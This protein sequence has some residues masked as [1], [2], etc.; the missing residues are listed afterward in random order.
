MGLKIKNYKV[1]RLGCTLNEAYAAISKMSF[2]GSAIDAVMKIQTTRE[3]ALNP[4]LDGYDE[5]PVCCKWDRKQSIAE[6][7]YEA[8]KTQ[9]F[10]DWENDII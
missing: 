9:G 3:N 2:N 5:K 6:A 4:D 10:E 8:A 1:E 7:V